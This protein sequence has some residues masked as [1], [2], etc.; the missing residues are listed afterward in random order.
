MSPR[1]RRSLK[2]FGLGAGVFLALTFSGV[3]AYV[4][5]VTGE[6]GILT[7]VFGGLSCAGV[8]I[9]SALVFLVTGAIA[10]GLGGNAVETVSGVSRFKGDSSR[11]TEKEAVGKKIQYD[12]IGTPMDQHSEYLKRDNTGL[13]LLGVSD[14]KMRNQEIK[15]MH[16]PTT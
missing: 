11:H 6:G 8:C 5:K 13:S 10:A 15:K 12:T 7:T 4:T 3:A 16:Y 2:S 9:G 14:V 1:D